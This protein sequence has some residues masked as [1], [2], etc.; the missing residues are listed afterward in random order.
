ML[1]EC[2]EMVDGSVILGTV[3]SNR[4]NAPPNE[5]CRLVHSVDLPTLEE[6]Q[7][8]HHLRMGW[9]PFKPMGKAEPC[10]TCGAFYYP[11]HT[12][13]CYRC[14]LEAEKRLR[15]TRGCVELTPEDWDATLDELVA[16][17]PPSEALLKLLEEG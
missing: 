2:W 6:A 5:R 11:E 17:S 15:L 9:E 3:E 14:V 8:V 16:P 10:P 4:R 7:A 12:G 1:F 13:K